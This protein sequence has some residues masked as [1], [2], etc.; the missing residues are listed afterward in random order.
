MLAR[1]LTVILSAAAISACS[2][3]PQSAAEPTYAQ[4][5][6]NPF[7]STNYLATDG[8]LKSYQGPAYAS[9]KEATAAG[10]PFVVATLVN[11]VI[12]SYSIH[13]TK[14]YEP[15]P[16]SSSPRWSMSISLNSRPRWAER[17]PNRFRRGLPKPVTR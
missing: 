8:L 13:Y 17:F 14:L 16:R 2:T 15:A 5:A 6:A 11:V 12:T 7:R 1:A 10:A 4:A 3:T 9:N